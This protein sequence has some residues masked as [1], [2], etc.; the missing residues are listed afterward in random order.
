MAGNGTWSLSGINTSTIADGTI[1]Y[2]VTATDAAGNI[3]TTSQTATKDTVAPQVAISQ[4]TNPIDA[5]N[6][7]NTFAN[8]TGEVGA[9]ISVVASNGGNSVTAV[10]TVVDSQGNWSVSGI[11][12]SELADGTITY[13]VTATDVADNAVTSSMTATKTTV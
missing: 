8:G 10:T 4:V 2:T 11:D 3:T 6:D 13:T 12:V 9:T 1:T 7:N 5:S